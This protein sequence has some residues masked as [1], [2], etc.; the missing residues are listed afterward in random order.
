[1]VKRC[2]QD[3]GA[4]GSAA[5]A[6]RY[7]L[8]QRI[9]LCSGNAVVERRSHRRGSQFSLGGHTDLSRCKRQDFAIGAIDYTKS[10]A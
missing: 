7:G 10:S 3:N 4:Q 5:G 9:D 2:S 1:M 8:E 6:K